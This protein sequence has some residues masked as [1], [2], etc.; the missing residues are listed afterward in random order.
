MATELNLVISLLLQN[1][2]I[3]VGLLA[4][5]FCLIAMLHAR[6]CNQ[7]FT[8]GLVRDFVI[9]L[10]LSMFFISLHLFGDVIIDLTKNPAFGL[11]SFS[12]WAYLFSF[13]AVFIA[14]ICFVKAIYI[15]KKMAML[16]GFAKK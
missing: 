3:I 8:K 15:L 9:W 10:M 2:Q 1:W 11:N 5:S 13:L 12:N 4:A 16:Y 7:C 6:I 14:A